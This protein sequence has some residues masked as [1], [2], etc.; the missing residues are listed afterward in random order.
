VYICSPQR[1]VP[2]P[3]ARA[4]KMVIRARKQVFIVSSE[5]PGSA[6][7]EHVI[8]QQACE[9]SPRNLFDLRKQVQGGTAS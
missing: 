1:A 6:L 2:R 3:G 8:L 5:M 4:V 9:P 7:V